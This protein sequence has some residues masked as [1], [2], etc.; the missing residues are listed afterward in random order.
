MSTP[1]GVS[2][3]AKLDGKDYPVKGSY[4]F[5]SV[6]LKRVDDRTIEETDKRD[7]KIVGIY[8]MSIAPDGKKMTVVA[9]S[10]VTGRTS[11]YVA[12]KQ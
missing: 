10:K 8:K 2:Y 4:T 9:T 5:N 1:T 12:E 3:T 7:G 11:T 6:S